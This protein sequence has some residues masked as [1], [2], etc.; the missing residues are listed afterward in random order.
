M[1]LHE[2]RSAQHKSR[3]MCALAVRIFMTLTVNH[4]TINAHLHH[5]A[6]TCWQMHCA[7]PPT[8]STSAPPVTVSFRAFHSHFAFFIE[9]LFMRSVCQF[10]ASCIWQRSKKDLILNVYIIYINLYL[11]RLS[12]FISV[13]EMR[14]LFAISCF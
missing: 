10:Y 7:P 8:P 5:L 6:V 3:I 12:V 9:F 2:L 1:L 13:L 14:I 4:Q 11:R